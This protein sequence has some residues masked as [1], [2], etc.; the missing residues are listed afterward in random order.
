MPA[1]KAVPSLVPRPVQVLDEAEKAIG[2][3]PEFRQARVSLYGQLGGDEGKKALA[4][5]AANLQ[6]VPEAEHNG[7]LQSIALAFYSLSDFDQ[8]RKLYQQLAENNPK[9]LGTELMVFSVSR[10]ANDEAAMKASV[11]KIREIAGEDNDYALFC[12]AA[13]IV[14][15][16]QN[17]VEQPSALAESA[18]VGRKSRLTAPDWGRVNAIARRNLRASK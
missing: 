15:L 14:T 8:A 18:G 17:K 10:D 11:E 7:I 3:K 1:F 12:D 5:M 16:V 9:D 13:R 6:D 4:E 2:K